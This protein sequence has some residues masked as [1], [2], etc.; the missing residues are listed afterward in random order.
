MARC[1]IEV[2]TKSGAAQS[3]F[4]FRPTRRQARAKVIEMRHPGGQGLSAELHLV[5]LPDGRGASDGQLGRAF[6]SIGHEIEPV[7]PPPPEVGRAFAV[8][9]FVH[10]GLE[11]ALQVRRNGAQIRIRH[12]SPGVPR[13]RWRQFP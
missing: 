8:G 11:P 2:S 6:L 5:E 9:H 13:H 12:V 3:R 1:L 7:L 4:L 10:D